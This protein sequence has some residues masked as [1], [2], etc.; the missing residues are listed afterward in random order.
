MKTH[1]CWKEAGT[2]HYPAVATDHHANALIIG[3]GITGVTAAYL[4]AKADKSVILLEK[5]ELCQGET[6]HTT[7]HI[8]YPTDIR[9]TELVK[10]FGED[11]AQAIWDAHQAAA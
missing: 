4:L 3:G 1:S 10:D 11:H 2:V 9:L 8:T 6:G 7:A 5:N